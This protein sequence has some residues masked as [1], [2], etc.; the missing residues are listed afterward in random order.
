MAAALAFHLFAG[1]SFIRHAAPTFDEPV[2]LAA[3]YSYLADGRNLMDLTGHPPFSEAMSALPL[4]AMKLNSF[5]THPYL[6]DGRMIRYSDLFLYDNTAGG[7]RMLVTARVFTFLVWTVLSVLFL[8]FFARALA[9]PAA[10]AFAVAAFCLMP[11]FISNNALITTDAGAA[12][13]FLGSVAAAWRFARPGEG[14][15][16]SGHHYTWAAIA[17]LLAG[18]AMTVKFSMFVVPPFI[19]GMWILDAWL[20]RGMKAGRLLTYALFFLAVVFMALAL[21]CRLHPLAYFHSLSLTLTDI[22]QGRSSFAWGR[23]SLAGVWWY[24]PLAFLV[25]TPTAVM[26]L[27]AAGAWAVIKKG[28]KSWFWVL[29][30]PLFYFAASFASKVQ[31]G[32]RHILPVMPFM[33]LAAGL[34]ADYLISKRKW[35]TGAAVLLLALPWALMLGCTHPFY[36]AYFNELAGGPANGYKFLVDSN[37]DWGQDIKTLGEYLARRGSPPVVLSYFGAARPEAYGVKYTPL[38]T[39]LENIF[40]GTG[41]KVNDMKEILLAVSA[42]NLQGVYYPDK[43]SFAWLKERKPVFAAG[44]SIFLYDL[45]A[46]KDGLG[47]L[48]ALLDRDGRNDEADSLYARAAKL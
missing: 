26:L 11:A 25:K 29:V 7:Q 5:S 46:D 47:R 9:G 31:I 45:T 30:P 1:L 39:Y 32:Y 13:F 41:V 2:H 16:G 27:A 19:I 38:G 44:Y 20:T 6:T 8:F 36:L 42:T 22:G 35:L 43:A 48:G 33:A 17:G 23:Y 15:R 40:T 12:V 21:V 3:G 18:L 10:A 24:F 37:L 34:G 4:L 14:S 28:G